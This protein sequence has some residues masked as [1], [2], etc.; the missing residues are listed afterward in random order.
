MQAGFD[1]LCAIVKNLN[2]TLLQHFSY[3]IS[4]FVAAAS[5]RDSSSFKQPAFTFIYFTVL[6]TFRLYSPDDLQESLCS[7]LFSHMYTSIVTAQHETP[8]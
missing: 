3:K 2:I 6:K 7:S 4:V 5:H 8:S 1:R